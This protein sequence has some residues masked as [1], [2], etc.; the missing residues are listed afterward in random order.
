MAQKVQRFV[1]ITDSFAVLSCDV[2]VQKRLTEGTRKLV[3]V[4]AAKEE[5]QLYKAATSLCKAGSVS[6]A[7]S[8]HRSLGDRSRIALALLQGHPATD[9]QETS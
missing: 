5:W 3:P 7:V 9:G 6:T 4:V 1:N 8:S 2:G